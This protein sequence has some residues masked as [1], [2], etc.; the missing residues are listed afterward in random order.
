MAGVA[1]LTPLIRWS[2]S[3]LCSPIFVEEAKRHHAAEAKSVQFAVGQIG[4]GLRLGEQA[5]SYPPSAASI[6][7]RSSMRG[8]EAPKGCG[9][10]V[11]GAEGHQ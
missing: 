1:N 6:S 4:D 3:L 9:A 5:G 11:E 8:V 2:R 10:R 7:R